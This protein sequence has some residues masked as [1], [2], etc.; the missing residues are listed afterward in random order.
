MAKTIEKNSDKA[1]QENANSTAPIG[2]PPSGGSWKWNSQRQRW[3]E[4][5][6]NQEQAAE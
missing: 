1:E 2:T 5:V 3:V 6:V 4:I